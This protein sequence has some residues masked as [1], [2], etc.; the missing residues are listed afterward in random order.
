MKLNKSKITFIALSLFALLTCSGIYAYFTDSLTIHNR[1]QYD[2]V[3]IGLENMMTNG[4]DETVPFEIPENIVPEQHISLIPQITNKGAKCYIRIKPQFILSD[5]EGNEIE[6]D[7]QEGLLGI[8]EESWVLA[9]DGYYYYQSPVEENETVEF[10]KT[11]V[12][13]NWD[14]SAADM[15][16]TLT[17]TAEAVQERNFEPDYEKADMEDDD[18]WNGVKAEKVVKSRVAGGDSHET[19]EQQ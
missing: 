13:P 16:Y 12:V 2:T 1:M 9:K 11:L 6:Y 17:L 5:E 18:C 3:E 7:I 19:T 15:N 10:F 14:N 8:D 4:E